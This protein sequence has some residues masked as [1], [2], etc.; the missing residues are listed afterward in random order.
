[1][2]EPAIFQGDGKE[3][4]KIVVHMLALPVAF[5][6]RA[7]SSADRDHGPG[8]QSL[9]GKIVYSGGDLGYA[10]QGSPI[11]SPEQRGYPTYTLYIL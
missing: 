2:A 10:I 11:G 5:L 9:A 7:R 3:K 6:L 8:D 4:R 1:V